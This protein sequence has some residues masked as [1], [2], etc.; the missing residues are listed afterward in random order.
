[1]SAHEWTAAAADFARFVATFRRF[2]LE[3]EDRESQRHWA[4]QA[5][6]FARYERR[7]LEAAATDEPVVGADEYMA[8][9]RA[10]MAARL[11]EA[12]A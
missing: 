3:A 2:A 10:L 7:A 1:V 9:H 11:A 8:M 4:A 5:E 6:A 12:S